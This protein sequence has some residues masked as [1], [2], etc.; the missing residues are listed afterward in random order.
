MWVRPF[1]SAEQTPNLLSLNQELPEPVEIERCSDTKR[2]WR[3]LMNNRRHFLKAL[4]TSG[5]LAGA[6]RPIQLRAAAPGPAS[7]DSRSAWLAR[8][9]QVTA[10]VLKNLA[11]GTLRARMPVECPQGR[12][13]DRRKVTHLEALGRTLT[14]IAPW[15]ELSGTT[16]EEA[17]WQQEWRSLA[18]RALDQATDPKSPDFLAFEAGAQNLVDAAFLA[19]ALLRARRELWENLD[20]A[21]RTRVVRSMEKTRKFKP[22][23]NNW[24]LFAAMVETFLARA[25]AEWKPEPIDLALR[26]HETWYKGDS[27]YGDGASFHWDYYNSFVIQPMLIDV[28]EGIAPVSARW[29]G[30]TAKVLARAR[31]QAGIQERLIAP[32]GTYPVIGR[33]IAY[34]CGAFQLL[35]QMALREQ[36]PAG[37]T[38]AQVRSALSAVLQRTLGA[39][40]TFDAGGWLRIGV[41]G[42][43]PGL[44]ESYISTGSL[45]LCSAVFLPLGLP[46][47]HA[48]WSVPAA[49]WTARKV[50]SGQNLP[51]DHAM[52][53]IR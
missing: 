43:Q 6:G 7:S 26:S 34:R 48:F 4:G 46:A 11:E 20:S 8:L 12:L 27:V 14:G 9:M 37:V 24:L 41:A 42:A 39:P 49:D 15:L 19:H 31:R 5:L 45:Y 23:N 10:P 35:A 22:G 33:S 18:H 1:L 3:N 50:W 53:E 30:Q 16:G 38:A 36:L 13:E 44:G 32:D 40:G 47:G 29:S 28:L 17:G 25:G 21:V 2:Q 51:A 52:S